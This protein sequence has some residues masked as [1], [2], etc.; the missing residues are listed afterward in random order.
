MKK[1]LKYV[2]ICAIVLALTAFILLCACNAIDMEAEVY[3]VK[4][5]DHAK[6]MDLIFNK[7]KFIEDK[8][9]F[10]ILFAWLTAL[11]GL[12]AG[13]AYA[14]L[15]LLGKGPEKVLKILG[16][17]AGGLLVFSGIIVMFAEADMLAHYSGEAKKQADE[18]TKFTFGYAFAGIL[19]ILAG[20]G[21]LVPP[22]LKK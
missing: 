6:G 22:F 15:G 11:L 7:D 9:N 5:V 2:P 3:G 19:N 21:L 16:L 8:P 4:V 12:L 1:L 14:V 10:A 17:V 20:A 18:W 13:A